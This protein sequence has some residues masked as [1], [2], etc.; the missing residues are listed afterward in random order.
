MAGGRETLR[1]TLRI[2]ATWLS[3]VLNAVVRRSCGLAPGGLDPA[4]HFPQRIAAQHHLVAVLQERAGRAVGQLDRLLA[5]PAQ[6]DQ[7][8]ALLALR[9][10]DRPGGQ[11]VAGPQARAVHGEVRDLLGD[12]PVEV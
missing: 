7:A 9:P 1:K 8:S 11:Q 4:A 12:G 5:V 6:L 3:W 2:S 10:R